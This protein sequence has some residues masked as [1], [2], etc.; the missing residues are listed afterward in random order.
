MSWPDL[1]AV[2][3]TRNE[4][5]HVGGCLASIGG[6]VDEIVVL[7]SHS[8]DRTREIARSAGAMVAERAFEGFGPQKQ[9]ALEM[10]RGRWVLII[11][12]DERITPRL[13][14]EIRRV[15]REPGDFAGFWIRREVEY[16]GRRLQHGGAESDWVLRLARRDLARFS[17]DMIHEHLAVSGRTGQLDGT[18][19]H[20]KWSTLGA[21]LAQMDTYTDMIATR[22]AER[23]ARFSMWH[24][25]RIP[26]EL[27]IRLVLRRGVL[28]GRAGVIHAGMASFYAFLK[29]ARLYERESH[30]A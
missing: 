21:H 27:F 29:Y 23:G 7:D 28:D 12:A 15:I 5:C 16:L 13:A 17:D 19:L 18:I 14:E 6:L 4:E 3:I 30:D 2:I 10:A 9:A 1:S 20:L 25:L 24:V 26:W 22:K 11:D 8:E